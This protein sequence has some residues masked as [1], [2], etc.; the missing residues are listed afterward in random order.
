MGSSSG[1]GY[2]VAIP[3][4]ACRSDESETNLSISKAMEVAADR[5]DGGEER[6]EVDSQEW[7]NSSTEEN[8]LDA[9]KPNASCACSKA[10]T[11]D[12]GNVSEQEDEEEDDIF[13][14]PEEKESV[15]G[16]PGSAVKPCATRTASPGSSTGL[17]AH[18]YAVSVD[19]P[20]ALLPH[21]HSV[22]QRVHGVR[23]RG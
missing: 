2:S 12:H 8:V 3:V 6:M 18:K 10:S 22:T 5:A 15:G 11:D 7:I 1:A 23:Q 13:R 20:P 9:P 19:L 21:S 16:G 17:P 14:S 4:S